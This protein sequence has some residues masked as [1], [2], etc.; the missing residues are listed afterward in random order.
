MTFDLQTQSK[1]ISSINRHLFLILGMLLMV[2]V[3]LQFLILATVGTKGAEITSIR[4]EKDTLRV[5]NESLRAEI[6]KV[7]TLEQ[8]EEKVNEVYDLEQKKV[9]TLYSVGYAEDQYIGSLP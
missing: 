9:E 6:D 8:V 2:F 7:K 3:V 5:E 4:I 1:I